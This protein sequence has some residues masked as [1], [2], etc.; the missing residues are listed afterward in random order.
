MQRIYLLFAIL[1]AFQFSNAQKVNINWGT[2]SKKELT[3]GS[4]VKGK[5]NEMIKLCF[6]EKHSG[7]LGRTVTSTPVLTRFSDKLDELGE[8]VYE[9]D[10]KNI[11]FNNLL[12]IKG[13]LFLFTSQYDKESKTT[14]YYCQGVNI[15]TLNTEGKVINLGAFDAVSKTSQSSIG[16]EISK[17]STKI[18]MFGNNAYKKNE[19]EK[20]YIAVFDNTMKKLWDK[21]IEL[22]YKDKYV[23]IS[24]S[25]ITNDGKVGVVIKHYD[26]EVSREVIS[27]DG[28]KVPS[29]KTKM[30][31]YDSE[32]A[33][34]KEFLLDLNNKFV[35]SLQLA[36]DDKDN[37]LLFGLYKEKY[38]GF[39]SG[40]FTVNFDKKTSAV[41][42][43]NINP[44]PQELVD[45]IRVDRQG[46]NRERDPG[47]ANVFRLAATVERDNGTQDF[48]LEYSS[49]IY[50][51]PTSSYSNGSWST[52]PGYWQYDYGDMLD[53]NLKKDGKVIIARVPKMQS[54]R[55]VRA[56][57]N[58]VAMPYKE[59]LLLFYNDDDDNID[60]E[61]TKK[62]DPLFKFNKSV[63]VMAIIDKTGSV[64]RDILFKNRDN[65]LTTATRECML[66]DK[67]KI[68]LY[69]QKLGGFFTSA[70][71]MIGVLEVK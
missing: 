29:Y 47:L 27:K 36:N 31:I 1:F 20:Y 26:A 24:E 44:F 7:F 71:D 70:K 57:S 66:F 49:E 2:E 67:N 5:G 65:K 4:Y 9:V 35:Q 52:T 23:S 28:E 51:P 59:S 17:D 43:N 39:I 41:T 16:Y 18:L 62:P 8:R 46:S 60:R 6:E 64:T 63:F 58:F 21:T 56:F 14:N 53:I 22:P 25:L 13:K 55:N 61:I 48:V 37:I 15:E 3:F 34:P 50:V 45:Q 32:N 12:S 11:S 40:F 10:D 30:L 42:T 19:N 38:N 68:G 54:S 33:Q 69:A